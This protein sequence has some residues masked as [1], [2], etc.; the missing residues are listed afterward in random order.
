[1]SKLL[2]SPLPDRTAAYFRQLGYVLQLTRE[3]ELETA[4]RI[5]RDPGDQ[6]GA[7]LTRPSTRRPANPSCKPSHLGA[8]TG[9]RARES[10]GFV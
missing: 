10:D 4:K 5:G 9:P 6:M 3:S 7:R 2:A 8:L 1:M